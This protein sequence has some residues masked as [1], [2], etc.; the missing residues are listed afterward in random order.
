MY[1]LDTNTCIYFL[2]GSSKSVKQKLLA[3]P[4]NEISIPALV[5]AELLFGAFKSRNRNDNLKKVEMFLKPFKTVSFDTEASY[6]YADIRFRCEA[7]GA[8]IGPNDL[9]VAAIVAAHDGVLVTDNTK[10]FSRIT[11]LRTEDWAAARIL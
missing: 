4:P 9:C 7:K 3:T 10:E 8:P 2:N 5:E 11:G 6:S 1:F